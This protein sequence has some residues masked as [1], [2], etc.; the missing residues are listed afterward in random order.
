M[1]LVATCHS[2]SEAQ[3]IESRLRLDGI[4]SHVLEAS[5]SNMK[6]PGLPVTTNVMVGESD[7]KKAQI[8][9]QRE[10][11]TQRN[12]GVKLCTRCSDRKPGEGSEQRK[13][14]R[15][16]SLW[17]AFQAAFLFKSYCPNCR[18]FY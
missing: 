9:I 18:G 7:V 3:T 17:I 16:Y 15:A 2:S 6:V 13:V 11:P 1:R 5:S 10:F 8:I 4:D 12:A 14:G